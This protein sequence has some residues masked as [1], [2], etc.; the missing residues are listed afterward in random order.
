[1]YKRQ[2]LECHG[3]ETLYGGDRDYCKIARDPAFETP[4]LDRIQRLVTRDKN[5]PCVIMWSMGNESGFGC[6]FEK[7]LAWTCLLYTSRCV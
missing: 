6:N 5:H 3:V 7:A 4:I 2:D 1:M